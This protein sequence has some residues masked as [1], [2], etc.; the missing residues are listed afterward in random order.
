M[1]D[2]EWWVGGVGYGLWVLDGKGKGR[3]G[4]VGGMGGDG[5][6]RGKGARDW[7][8]CVCVGGEGR[9]GEGTVIV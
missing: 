8:V 7:V 3:R 9:G 2:G 5:R 6:R 4:E 1:V